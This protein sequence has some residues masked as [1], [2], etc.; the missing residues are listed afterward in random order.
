[1]PAPSRLDE[2]SP[3]GERRS[4][5]RGD[6]GRAR[7]AP[8]RRRERKRAPQTPPPA[9]ARV[10]AVFAWASER[11]RKRRYNRPLFANAKEKAPGPRAV[12]ERSEETVLG[13]AKGLQGPKPARFSF[14]LHTE[15]AGRGRP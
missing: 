7:R 13:G 14:G 12:F 2:A 10:V 1:M 15:P 8:A 9:H 11:A 3:Q 6:R 5:G 4:G